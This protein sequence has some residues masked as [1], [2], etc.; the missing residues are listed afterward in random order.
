[1]FQPVSSTFAVALAR[2]APQTMGSR[3]IDRGTLPEQRR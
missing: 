1:M 3:V 2:V